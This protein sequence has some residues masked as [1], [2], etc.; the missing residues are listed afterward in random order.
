MDENLKRQVIEI[1]EEEQNELDGC[2]DNPSDVVA[3]ETLSQTSVTQNAD[4]TWTSTTTEVESNLVDGSIDGKNRVKIKSKAEILQEFCRIVDNKILSINAEINIKKQQIVDLSTE[5]TNGNCWPGIGY[6][7]TTSSGTTRNLVSAATSS[8]ITPTNIKNEIENLKIYPKLAGPNVDYG[9]Q[10][11]FEPD[12]IYTLTTNYA[13]YGY[14]NLKEPV[15]FRNNDNTPTGLRTD[16]S[17]TNLGTGRFDLSTTLADHSLRNVAPFFAYA[18]AGVAPEASNTSMTAARCV[19]I[20]SSIPALYN[21]I[22][23][24]RQSR[25]SLRSDLNSVK[26]NKKE[27]EIASWGLNRIEHQVKARKTVNVSAIEAVKSF[28]S[29]ITVTGEALVLH[30]DVGNSNSYS[31]IGTSWYDLSGYGNHATLFPIASPASYE[32]SNG[33]FLTFNGTDEYAETITKVADIIG[34]GDWTIEVWFRVN[35]A[36]SDT[37]FSNVIVDTNPTASSANMLNV[38][39]G[40]TAPF[41]GITTNAFAYSSRP[42][43]S[44]SYTH[45]VGAGVTNSLWYHGAVV[46]NGTTNTKLYLNGNLV[47]TH[48]GD[49]PTDSEGFVRIARYTDSNSFSNISVSV[50]KIYQ[51]AFAD[52]EIRTKFDGSRSRYGLIG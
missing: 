28:T 7:V 6:S 44:A 45:L 4:G 21:E 11:V 38:T 34:T 35:G 48:T 41:V 30:L 47:N 12:T 51:R 5:A 20:A 25:D 10:N 50:V 22:I 46:R 31:G 15:V 49:L 23:A 24:L 42:N 26:N 1:L 16:G 40:T 19:A 37:Q 13:G 52:S 18:G 32:V 3:P 9:A 2:L 33:G 14:A 27:K 39:F 43:A 36:P 8:F 29:A 17:G